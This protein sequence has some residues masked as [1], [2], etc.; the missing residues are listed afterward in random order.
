MALVMALL[1]FSFI[2]VV[3]SSCPAGWKPGP[4]DKCYKVRGSGIG[5]GGAYFPDCQEYCSSAAP[6]G[7]TAALACITSQAQNDFIVKWMN[8][9]DSIAGIP[10]RRSTRYFFWIGNYQ[11]TTNSGVAHGWTGC[12]SDEATHDFTSWSLD[13][14]SPTLGAQPDDNG[15]GTA[16]DCAAITAD[17][18]YDYPCHLDHEVEMYCLCE[19]GVSWVGL[20]PRAANENQANPPTLSSTSKQ[21]QRE[22]VSRSNDV[23]TGLMKGLV[24]ASFVLEVCT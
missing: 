14:I 17:G 7:Q 24:A 13:H 19:L 23:R 20:G 3:Q 11:V 4:E 12:V 22:E 9:E 5:S 2:C 21:S 6:D 1:L 16:E 10:G 15:D 8:D 18:W